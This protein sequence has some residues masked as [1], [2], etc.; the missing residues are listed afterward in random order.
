MSRPISLSRL[1]EIMKYDPDTGLFTRRYKWWNKVLYGGKA[2][3]YIYHQVDDKTYATHWLAWF[4]MTGEWPKHQI[5][6]KNRIKSDNK[7]LNLR[8]ATQSQ[9]LM[10]GERSKR[11]KSGYRGVSWHSKYG[12]WRAC[13]SI[14]GKLIHLGYAETAEKA[15]S[16]YI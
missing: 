5:D 13:I 2:G 1:K 15:Y 14:D 6:H 10:N 7:F 16:L 3:Y 12:K 11:N 8:E 4:Y 9:N